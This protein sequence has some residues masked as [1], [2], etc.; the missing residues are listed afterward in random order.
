MTSHLCLPARSRAT[1]DVAGPILPIL[2]RVPALRPPGR[3]GGWPPVRARRR[4][5]RKEVRLAGLTLM[6][7]LPASLLLLT[8]GGA[9]PVARPAVSQATGVPAAPARAVESC[10]VSLS[11]E[12]TGDPAPRAALVSVPVVFPGYL[13]PGDGHE[14]SAHA[15]R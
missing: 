5:L 3:A 2:I 9:R 8:L 7:V 10:R 14:E 13:L 1:I 6:S 11:F 4:R 12:P 15:R